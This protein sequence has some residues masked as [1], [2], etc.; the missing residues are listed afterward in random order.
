M[1][2]FCKQCQATVSAVLCQILQ[3][4]CGSTYC[5]AKQ[6]IL[7]D[8]WTEEGECAVSC[9]VCSWSGVVPLKKY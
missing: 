6:A 1:T 9:K 4:T 5:G 8:P 3:F 7:C 2:I